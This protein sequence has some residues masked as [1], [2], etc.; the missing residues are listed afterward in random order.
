M[1]VSPEIVQLSLIQ[2][3]SAIIVNTK[4]TKTFQND[5]REQKTI[6]GYLQRS[7]SRLCHNGW[8]YCCCAELEKGSFYSTSAGARRMEDIYFSSVSAPSWYNLYIFAWAMQCISTRKSQLTEFAIGLDM[9]LEEF[10]MK[11]AGP[12]LRTSSAHPMITKLS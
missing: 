2:E 5:P 7:D 6:Q 9:E 8:R 12:Q 1:L 10:I 3:Q 4:R 11:P